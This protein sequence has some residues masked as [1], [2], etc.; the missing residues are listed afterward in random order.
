MRLLVVS[1]TLLLVASVIIAGPVAAVKPSASPSAT[2]APTAEPTPGADPGTD[3]GADA[4]SDRGAHRRAD[5]GTDPGADSLEPVRRA[6]HRAVGGPSGRRASSRRSHL[7]SHQAPRSR[8]ARRLTPAPP[9]PRS[10][11]ASVSALQFAGTSPANQYVT[12]GAAPSLGLST[13]TVEA[14]VKRTGTGITTTTSAVGGGG[15]HRLPIV[16]KGRGEGD[17][18]NV[19]M[20]YFLGIDTAT[21]RLAADFE[22]AP[23]GSGAAGLNHS[24]IGTTAITSNVW[25]HVAVTYDGTWRLYFDGNPDGT[26][27][28]NEP[29]RNDSIQHSGIATAMTSTGAAAGFFAGVID[30]VRIWSV[31]RTAG[32]VL[33]A[34]DSELTS[35]TGLVG[36]WGMNE[37]SGTAVDNSIAGGVNGTALP[38]AGPPTWVTG[39]D[40]PA[41]AAPVAVAD[42]YNTP[43]DTALVQAAPG[44]LAN[45]TDANGDPLTAVLNTNVSNGTLRST[46]MVASPT[47][48]PQAT[49]V[50]TASPTTPTTAPPTRTW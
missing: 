1:Q 22:E 30:E 37:G 7:P 16:T 9:E 8:P 35:G 29:P 34:K 48:R 25:H 18:T 42:S 13:F 44:V 38:L 11:A 21:N 46:P 5:C 23:A 17:G 32:T 49:A 50:P 47:P 40:P 31:A 28:V 39:F 36:R 15:L 33:A 3:P 2:P 24:F 45:D 4:R 41:P 43:Q 26:L 20:N 19:D 6:E 14:W 12:F 10:L 27:A